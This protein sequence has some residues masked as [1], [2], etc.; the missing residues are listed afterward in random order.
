MSSGRNL[1]NN[2]YFSHQPPVRLAAL[3]W[4]WPRLPLLCVPDQVVTRGLLSGLRS[5]WACCLVFL[6]Q[7]GVTV[8][9]T[10]GPH[11]VLAGVLRR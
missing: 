4:F 11:C 5:L 3:G 8:Q 6:L 10:R 2:W 7:T 1:G 9:T